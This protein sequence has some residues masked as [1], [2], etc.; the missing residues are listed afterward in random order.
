MS[1]GTLLDSSAILAF[2][3]DE[4]GSDKVIAA[5]HQGSVGC[6]VANWAEVVSKIVSRRGDWN[7]AEA[8]LLG[9]GLSLIPIEADDAVAAGKLWSNHPTLSLG[10]RLCLAVGQRLGGVIIT[11]DRAWTEVSELVELIR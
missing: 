10:D 8:A 3:W 4:P 6:T 7:A 1:M 11:A 9:R 5:F 2:L